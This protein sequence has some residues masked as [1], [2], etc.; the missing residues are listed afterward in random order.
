MEKEIFFRNIINENRDRIYRICNYYFHEAD[1]R[2]DAFQETLIRIWENLAS[3]KNKS[4]ISTWIYRVTVN[5]CLMFI[6]K[7]R[8]RMKIFAGVEATGLTNLPDKPVIED[9]PET[10]RKLSFFRS[11]LDE[12]PAMERTIV[13]L[14][15]EELST[16]EMA[17]ITGLSET[18]IR[19]RIHRL[20]ERI[21]IKWKEKYH[22]IK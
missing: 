4:K 19:V 20:K 17:D 3:F 13:S 11:F 12:I 21:N 2:D 10:E 8:S 9:D 14:Y 16:R 15:L 18:N 7:D 6:R 5:T 22:G 1:D